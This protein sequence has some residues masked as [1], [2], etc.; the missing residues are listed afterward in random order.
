MTNNLSTIL[1]NKKALTKNEIKDILKPIF[2][3]YRI[4]RAAMFGSYA[5]GD[6]TTASDI[7][8][9]VELDYEHPLTEALYGFWDDAEANLGF[10][11]DLLSFNSLNESTKQKFKRQVLDELEWFYEA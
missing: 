11:V 5:R 2:P 9:I 6:F 8:I 10:T 4:K 3:K 1:Q 7:D